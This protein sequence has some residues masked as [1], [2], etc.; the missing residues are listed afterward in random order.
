MSDKPQAKRPRLDEKSAGGSSST[1]SSDAGAAA[2]STGRSARPVVDPDAEL[3]EADASNGEELVVTDEMKAEEERLAKQSEEDEKKR[4]AAEKKALKT[5]SKKDKVERL[6]HLLSKSIAY[7]EFLAD[8]IKKEGEGAIAVQDGSVKG[9]GLPQPKLVTGGEMRP[10]QLVGVHWLVGLYENGLN[11]ILGDEMGLGKTVQSVALVAH[12]KEHDVSG[13]FMVVGPLSTLHNWKNEFAKWTPDIPA[14]IYHG[15]QK[16]RQEMRGQFLRSKPGKNG[17]AKND[18]PVLII[19]YEIVIR[20]A[21][22]LRKCGWKFVIIDEGHRLKNLNCRLIRELKTICD[23]GT[24]PCNRLL[25]TG[26]PLQN[27]LTE[28]WSLLNFLLPSIFDDLDSF[29]AWFDF[30]FSEEGTEEKVMKGEMQDGVVTKLHQILR[31]FLLRRLKADVELSVPKKY[32]YILFG[33]MSEWQQ[34]MYQDL[35]NKQLKDSDGKDM[36]MQNVLMQLRKCCNHPYLFEWP[37]DPHTG[38]EAVDEILVEASGK[39]QLLD[40]ILTMLKNDKKDK[41][42]VLIF[43]Q[44]TRMLDILEDYLTWRGYKHRRLD[45]T[46]SAID[47]MQAMQDFNTDPTIDVFLLSTRAGGLGVN[48][49]AADTCIIFDSDWNPQADL[50][51]Q[52]RCHRIGQSKTVL[53]FR[54]ATADTVEE[55]ILHAAK[56]KLKLEQ[57][58]VSKGKFKDIGQKTDKDDKIE[59]TQLKELLAFD[60]SKTALGRQENSKIITDEELAI[61][62]ERSGGT[63]T[64][65]GFMAVEKVTNSFDALGSAR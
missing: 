2:T 36:R 57:L 30:D 41:H 14:I 49:V 54:L 27:N 18:L 53:V 62:L 29:Q 1:S 45:G 3:L 40:R 7:S 37:L 46:V 58:V 43:S 12:L 4:M 24:T 64:G 60:P 26:T 5:S 42:K 52:D 63:K 23:Q 33:W 20:D 34:G 28:L 16:E 25:L 65:K 15:P 56:Q 51:A 61:V 44:M 10:Y 47:R 21:K 32:E 22:E 8:K 50:Q 11:G 19:S 38:N 48:L 31:P 39:M 13:P 55:K 35:I 6:E 17:G 9:P 59:E